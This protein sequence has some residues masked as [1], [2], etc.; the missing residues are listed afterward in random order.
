LES[1]RLEAYIHIVYLTALILLGQGQKDDF[2][3][4]HAFF[5]MLFFRKEG[6]SFCPL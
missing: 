6:I 4:I 1:Y 2:A 3:L 5:P